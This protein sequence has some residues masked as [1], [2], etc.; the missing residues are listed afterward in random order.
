MTQESVNPTSSEYV[1][2]ELTVRARVRLPEGQ[3]PQDAVDLQADWATGVENELQ[4]N[5][6]GGDVKRFFE[7]VE[8]RVVSVTT[9]PNE[10]ELSNF[11]ARASIGAMSAEATNK[12]WSNTSQ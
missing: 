6:A 3:V 2:L 10:F 11:T 5:L 7:Q 1:E 12:F 8:A 9:D 4:R